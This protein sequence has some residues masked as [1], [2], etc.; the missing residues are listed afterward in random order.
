MLRISVSHPLPPR[1]RQLTPDELKRVFGGCIANLNEYCGVPS[2]CCVGRCVHG[3]GP[4]GHHF[5]R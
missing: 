1:P 4:E 5:C 2:D 3:G